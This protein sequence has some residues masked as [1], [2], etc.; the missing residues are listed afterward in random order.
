MSCNIPLVRK[1]LRRIGTALA[2]AWRVTLAL[3]R[4]TPLA[5]A[6]GFG[7]A[8]GILD[9]GPLSVLAVERLE[10]PPS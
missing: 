7:A 1:T 4:L 2:E 8:V 9:C 6:A 3:I 5:K 10:V